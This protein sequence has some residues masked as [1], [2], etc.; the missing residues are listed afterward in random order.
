MKKYTLSA[1]YVD[2]CMPCYLQDH[3]S[4]EGEMLLQCLPHGQ[5]IPEAVEDLFESESTWDR[6]PG[7]EEIS[8]EAIEEALT[9]ALE[10][11]DLQ[12]LDL[13]GNR[14]ESDPEPEGHAETCSMMDGEDLPLCT[15]GYDLWQGAE[16]S[17][18]YVVLRWKEEP[19]C[20]HSVDFTSFKMDGGLAL[21][22]C[23]HCGEPG[24]LSDYGMERLDEATRW[25]D[26]REPGE[27]LCGPGGEGRT[28]LPY[29]QGGGDA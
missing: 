25:N 3:H 22:K 8:Q 24:R 19:R 18:V 9:S 13:E 21:C 14:C 4:R 26:E 2:T 23:V 27:I 11:V 29:G 17:Y 20:T 28:D 7:G 15:C 6:F 10:G 16:P 5:S 12:Y 1:D